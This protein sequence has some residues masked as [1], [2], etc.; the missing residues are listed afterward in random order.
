MKKVDTKC[1]LDMV[2]DIVEDGKEVSI[3]ISGNSMSPF[4]ISQRDTIVVGPVKGCL[5]R[6]DMALYLRTTGQ[7]VMHR[8]HHVRKNHGQEQYYFIGDAQSKIEGPIERSQ[9]CGVITAVCRK[10]KWLR[11]G[12]FWWEFFRCIWIRI[13]PFR[14]IVQR[15]I[16]SRGHRG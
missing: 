5:H 3:L 15:M 12:D 10:G 4:L 2:K 14:R 1:Y 11:P 8:I 7:Y 13:V 9:I 16:P 6:G